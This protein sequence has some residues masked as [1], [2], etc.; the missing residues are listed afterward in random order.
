MCVC[1]YVCAYMYLHV[2]VSWSHPVC[3]VCVCVCVCVCACMR[4]HVCVLALITLS[5]LCVCVCVCAYICAYMFVCVPWSH[6]VCCACAEDNQTQFR[7]NGG[8][9]LLQ[10]HKVLSR[11][12]STSPQSMTKEERDVMTSAFDMMTQACKNNGRPMDHFSLDCSVWNACWVLSFGIGS[13]SF[14]FPLAWTTFRTIVQAVNCVASPSSVC[15]HS[16]LD[17]SYWYMGYRN[18]EK[19][20]D[21]I[22]QHSLFHVSIY[23]LY[24]WWGGASPADVSLDCFFFLVSG[25]LDGLPA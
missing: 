6:P 19:K 18:T 1:V 15:I 14:S 2:C 13:L 22:L 3:C 12:L 7:V 11:C 10:E 24:C 23:A 16:Q 9:Q 8:L 21:L 5:M 17:G 20:T 25:L 4:L